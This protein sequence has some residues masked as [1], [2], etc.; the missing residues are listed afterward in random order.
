M[1]MRM[2]MRMTMARGTE[3]NN[4]FGFFSCFK[5]SQTLAWLWKGG[6]VK[7]MVPANLAEQQN[8]TYGCQN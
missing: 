8:V 3:R 4:F 2:T 6:L 1:T 5:E 7:R